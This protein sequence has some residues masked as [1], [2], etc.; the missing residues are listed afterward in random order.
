MLLFNLIQN[1]LEFLGFILALFSSLSLHEAA[2]AWAADR[3]GDPTPRLAGRLTLNPLRHLNPLGTLFFLLAGFGWGNPV[4]FDP[5]NFKNPKIDALK[6]ALAGP[7]SNFIFALALTLIVRFLPMNASLIS[8]F[9]TVVTLNI[10]WM[11]FNLLPIPPLDGSHILAVVLPSRIYLILQQI[12]L[13][14]LII[15]L[16]A[17]PVIHN[18]ISLGLNLYF[19]IFIQTDFSIF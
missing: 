3:L 17:S 14:L 12:G 15:L 19:R 7:I 1:P 8:L 9:L 16:L 2:H 18:L 11:I 13:P 10:I 5:N 4:P 6:V